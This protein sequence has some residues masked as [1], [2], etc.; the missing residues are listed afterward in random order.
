MLIYF[1]KFIL[2]NTRYRG[3]MQFFSYPAYSFII[4]KH[5]ICEQA[6]HQNLKITS[7]EKRLW[8]TS[9]KCL[10]KWKGIMLTN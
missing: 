6:K 3:E 1:Y 2:E 9:A 8:N 5:D 7:I 10:W 4:L